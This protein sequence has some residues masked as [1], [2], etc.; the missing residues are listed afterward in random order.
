[1]DNILE[2]IQSQL[3]LPHI[4]QHIVQVLKKILTQVIPSIQEYLSV[5][6]Q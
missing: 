2:L 1:M 4:L 5:K 6:D 3:Y